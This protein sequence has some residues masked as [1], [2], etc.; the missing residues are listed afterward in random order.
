MG[1]PAETLNGASSPP[2]HTRENA[3]SAHLLELAD[4]LEKLAYDLE[5]P[6]Q[7]SDYD[8]VLRRLSAVTGKNVFSVDNTVAIN[9]AF[10]GA[11]DGSSVKLTE[12]ILTNGVKINIK[13]L[14]ER[15]RK[16]ANTIRS[17]LKKASEAAVQ[18]TRAAVETAVPKQQ[19]VGTTIAPGSD[20]L[21][22]GIT[23]DCLAS[24]CDG[25]LSM[26]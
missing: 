5:D 16:R 1:A 2:S 21:P 13:E 20:D 23:V 6:N 8:E 11:D 24:L 12:V 18:E 14:A 9:K 25:D 17:L 19:E 4:T 3:D 22:N 7:I 26:M 15:L 10:M